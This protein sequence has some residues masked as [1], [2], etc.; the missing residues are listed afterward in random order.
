MILNYVLVKQNRC[1]IIF[2]N[3][4]QGFHEHELVAFCLIKLF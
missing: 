4:F 3:D 2:S 1:V